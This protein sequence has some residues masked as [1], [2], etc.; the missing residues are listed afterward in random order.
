MRVQCPNVN[1]AV[2][3]AIDRSGDKFQKQLKT[4]YILF[5]IAEKNHEC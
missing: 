4:M 5:Y 3:D 2:N 1:V